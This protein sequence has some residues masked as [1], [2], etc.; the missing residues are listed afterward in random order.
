[1]ENTE[2]VIISTSTLITSLLCYSYARA[3]RKEAVPYVMVGAFL[4]TLIGEALA[5]RMSGPINK[6]V[7]NRIEME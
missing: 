4:G 6:S 3:A 7:A 5:E 1:M 2:K